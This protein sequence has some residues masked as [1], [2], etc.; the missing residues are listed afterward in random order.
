ME[1]EQTIGRGVWIVSKKTIGFISPALITGS[2]EKLLQKWLILSGV[3]F[4]QKDGWCIP[5]LHN[6]FVGLSNLVSAMNLEQQPTEK[7]AKL[8]TG[9]VG[10][11]TS[12]YFALPSRY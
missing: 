10:M 11:Y 7:A 1:R 3:W 6:G 2:K 8:A 5:P 9:N 4:C 12:I